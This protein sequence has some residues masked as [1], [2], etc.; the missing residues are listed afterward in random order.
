[1][2]Q[3]RIETIIGFLV[4]IIAIIFFCFAYKIVNNTSTNYGYKIFAD[5]QNID[6]IKEGAEIRISGIKV[7]KVGKISLDTE[8]Y[9]ANIELLIDQKVQ[10]PDDS[11]AIISTNGILGGNYIRLTPGASERNF[12]DGDKIIFTQSSLNIEELVN[13]LLMSF[14][15]KS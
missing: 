3:A 7:G 11:R 2:K 8:I 10:I 1:M 9:L 5:F 14:S 15:S 13:K 6:G 4:I 12:A